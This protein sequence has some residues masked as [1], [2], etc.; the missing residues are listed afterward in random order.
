MEVHHERPRLQYPI[1]TGN[2]PGLGAGSSHWLVDPKTDVPD[3]AVSSQLIISCLDV[4][5]A[6][7]PWALPSVDVERIFTFVEKDARVLVF[8][9]GGISRSTAVGIGLLVS[10]GITPA[11]ATDMVHEMRPNLAPNK[12]ILRYID[13]HLR[14]DGALM[15]QVQD[16]L[17]TYSQDLHLW[18]ADCRVYVPDIEGANCPG[19]HF[20]SRV[21]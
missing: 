6:M 10:R 5:S 16:T 18:C 9:N 14:M 13:A 17:S 20:G 15:Q 4:E 1:G 8:C 2:S 19:K 7:D 3:F 12:L 11:T 21:L